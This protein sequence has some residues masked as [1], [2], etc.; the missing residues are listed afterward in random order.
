MT[1]SCQSDHENKTKQKE[2]KKKTKTT[3][4]PKT[5]NKWK[6]RTYQIRYSSYREK[7]YHY[8][9]RNSRKTWATLVTSIQEKWSQAG[10]GSE[11]RDEDCKKWRLIPEKETRSGRIYQRRRLGVPGFIRPGIPV[12]A[13]N[14]QVKHVECCGLPCH[15]APQGL[16]LSTTASTGLLGAMFYPEPRVR[17]VVV[18][19]PDTNQRHT[20]AFQ[21]STTELS[22][23]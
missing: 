17:T 9:H 14:G 5:P 4:Q 15:P 11:K 22:H 2:R 13:C 6:P 18:L 3:N 21:R 16:Q 19:L 12:I 8:T 10:R 23:E 20:I 1:M 7:Y